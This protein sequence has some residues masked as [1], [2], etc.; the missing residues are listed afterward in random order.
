MRTEMNFAGWRRAG[1]VAA[2]GLFLVCGVALYAAPPGAGNRARSGVRPG[3]L[4]G[5]EIPI[6]PPVHAFRIS[7]VVHNEGVL[8]G[9]TSASADCI[10][11]GCCEKDL[12]CD[13][14]NTCTVD[15]CIFTGGLFQGTCEHTQRGACD[16]CGNDGICDGNQICSGAGECTF[17]VAALC[18]DDPTRICDE[19]EARQGQDPCVEPC[20]TQGVGCPTDFIG[21]CS[22]NDEIVC[23]N[24]T[25]CD[26]PLANGTC[27]FT[28]WC[29][30][31]EACI[32]QECIGGGDPGAR[33]TI[34]GDCDG[35]W[36]G[37]VCGH[38]NP[39]CGTES[40]CND[41]A[42]T[43]SLFGRCC[44]VDGSEP[45]GYACTRTLGNVCD[46]VWL[47]AGDKAGTSEDDAECDSPA[48]S[49]FTN[50]DETF[51]CPAY[52]AGVAPAG[53]YPNVLGPVGWGQK[54]EADENDPEAWHSCQ[55]LPHE[56]GDDYTIGL[57]G[58]WFR[59]S[60]VR[61][62]LGYQAVG[63]QGSASRYRLAFYDQDLNL[64][65]DTITGGSVGSLVSRRTVIYGENPVI[66][67][68]GYIVLRPAPRFSEMARFFWADTTPVVAGTGG[69]PDTVDVGSND[70]NTLWYNGGPVAVAD[71][72][73][74]FSTGILAFELDAERVSEPVHAC[75]DPLSGT[76]TEMYPW[77]CE[78]PLLNGF[79]R[80]AVDRNTSCVLDD[81][82]VKAGGGVCNLS[83]GFSQDA[84]SCQSCR[85]DNNKICSV[86]TD[87]PACSGDALLP[88]DVNIQCL[89]NPSGVCTDGFCDGGEHHE[90]VCSP[91]AEC[92][93]ED[94]GTC[95]PSSPCDP[96]PPQC[97]RSACC[98]E[99][100]GLP[101]CVGPGQDNFVYCPNGDSDCTD[102]GFCTGLTSGFGDCL[103]VFG[104]L[105]E[106]IAAGAGDGCISDDDCTKPNTC[107]AP[108]PEGSVSNGF[109]TNCDPNCCEQ[110]ET[111][112][113]TCLLAE[114]NKIFIEV[115]A[116]GDPPVTITFSG[117]NSNA[118]FGDH[119]DD[120]PGGG[121]CDFNLF[122][123]SGSF[124]DRGWWHSFS[125]DACAIVRVDNCCTKP[126]S[127]EIKQ[128]QWS[129]LSTSCSPCTTSIGSNVVSEP[130]GDNEN[131]NDRGGP[132]CD[133][134]DLW[135]TF[136]PVGEGIYYIP[137]YS[138]TDG[139]FGDYQVHVTVGACPL[140]VCCLTPPLGSTGYCVGIDSLLIRDVEG[141]GILCGDEA[142]CT[143]GTCETCALLT[144]IDCDDILGY[145]HGLGRIPTN[146][147]P[148]VDCDLATPCELGSCCL[149]PGLCQ[150]EKTPGVDCTPGNTT[151]CMDRATCNENFPEATFT[152]G[153]LCDF[154]QP[155]CP[156]C[157]IES[158]IN[159]QLPN[160]DGS[161]ISGVIADLTVGPN[162]SVAADDFIPL[163]TTITKV[164]VWGFYHN[165]EKTGDEAYECIGDVDDHFRVRVFK[166]DNGLPD[167]SETGLVGE[168]M[169]TGENIG[170]GQELETGFMLYG[171]GTNA[172][173][174]GYTLTLETPII[175][176]V[177]GAV[178]W[179]EVVNNTTGSG[180]SWK[181][182]WWNWHQHYPDAGGGYS[183]QGANSGG[184]EDEADYLYADSRYVPG[185]SRTWDLAFCLSNED[186]PL[187]IDP[188]TER[189]GA[190]W[191]CPGDDDPSCT[192][193]TH[194][195]CANTSGI[196]GVWNRTTEC[197][198]GTFDDVS[199]LLRG[200]DCVPGGGGQVA[201]ASA[202]E[203][204]GDNIVQPKLGEQCD[205]PDGLFCDE[206][207]H[208]ICAPPP[209]A[210]GV[211]DGGTNQD[212]ECESD[213]D[214]PP[215][216]EGHVCVFGEGAR[217]I[218]EGLHAVTT[219]CG[220][221]DGPTEMRNEH[222]ELEF[223]GF[224]SWFFHTA[225]C[226]GFL[227]INAC[228]T[229]PGYNE[230]GTG[231]LSDNFVGIYHDADNPTECPCP[232]EAAEALQY[233]L[234]S[235]EGCNG[236]GDQGPGWF[237]IPV[238][239]GDCY[240][241]RM[242][243]WGGSA[244]TA[245]RG[246]AMFDVACIQQDC[247]LSLA[248]EFEQLTSTGGSLVD[249]AKNRYLPIIAGTAGR[250]QAIRVIFKNLPAPYDVW[251]DAE[252]WA[253]PPFEVCES[254]SDIYPP[255]VGG[256]ETFLASRLSCGPPTA[257]NYR[258]WSALGVVNLIHEGIV[259]SADPDAP[260]IYEV[261]LIDADCNVSNAAHYS[262][263]LTMFTARYGDCIED[264]SIVPPGPSQGV[265][266]IQ[267]ATA[268]VA[269]F[270][271][272]PGHMS[273]SRG[274]LDGECINN[275]S[276]ITDVLQV[277]N[278]FNGLKAPY[279]PTGATACDSICSN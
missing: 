119:S 49:T 149:G 142:P 243:N 54:D 33:C 44:I 120:N 127:G 37:G 276:D 255:C 217:V 223:M 155:P 160:G 150:D 85:N 236:I 135:M 115:P 5:T 189:L 176:M 157:T 278:G 46:G 97:T 175:N 264:L 171:Y 272:A 235:D 87:C 13:D 92:A 216:G 207:C 261:Q 248:P 257:D 17:A 244:D 193:E 125:L 50:A 147:D 62:I 277:I 51:R 82:C 183:A 106:G 226:E 123:S 110:T 188:G 32:P 184:F 56:L 105:C 35:G 240:T 260:A 21:T 180:N 89:G 161:A 28:G 140:N 71:T 12:D 7:T 22:L 201:S 131:A 38:I 267:D 2:A 170:R 8:S 36:C 197:D 86:E 162:G 194:V 6:S 100:A 209:V 224:D 16:G 247:P 129:F 59:L 1:S 144:V 169:V 77:I 117:N 174:Q 137:V 45:T 156:A 271:S 265:V 168:S 215:L 273:K 75:C 173:S 78:A 73:W 114:A 102:L 113:D 238:I 231:N 256:P 53:P 252:M 130:V 210:V 60:T 146:I 163:G 181:R 66:P 190:C 218:V 43:C 41:L 239:P 47:N 242:A 109:G 26:P 4:E 232:G 200:G 58:E 68:S 74:P 18:S 63:I 136:G 145:W 172:I 99:I 186:G 199:D 182:C 91:D 270:Q 15:L 177:S 158:D 195:D 185:S 116:A 229:G 79:G 222:N 57:P 76:C 121:T 30:G 48:P 241:V 205:P 9:D 84:G 202:G 72:P 141:D 23:A 70:P 268:V 55:G 178:H 234:G 227:Y 179:L 94:A 220:N 230:T 274:E 95:G 275:R 134:D 266:T 3:T 52:A 126:R 148:L 27:Q 103:T 250:S 25:D 187:A 61:M 263:A 107:E 245:E 93:L 198:T 225:Q 112:Y 96:R 31:E 253:G 108:C 104:G 39:P 10:P 206:S 251:N 159:C 196:A 154:P 211:C 133:E 228:P 165:Q 258:D 128:P 101:Y 83:A 111:G 246:E 167:M 203:F 214:C 152:G 14:C 237:K 69:D 132:F 192:M 81:D 67:A 164:C 153:A 139:T 262:P 143:T 204:C 88:C 279:L 98:A 122:S 90:E 64:I 11:P 208:I 20:G 138:G 24:D 42:Q 166:D 65:E 233:G 191:T 151:T 19:E 213:D 29:N 124:K 259:P 212:G 80:C 249:N 269:V 254:G 34:D 118:T 40:G 219:I 221:N